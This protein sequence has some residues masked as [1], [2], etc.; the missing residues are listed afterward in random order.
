M[1]QDFAWTPLASLRLW[2]LNPRDNAEAIP[3]VAASIA[4]FGFVSPVVVWTSRSRIVAGHTRVLALARLLKKAPAFVPPGAPQGTPPG[5]APVRFHEFSSEEEATAYAIADNRLNELA[6]W[7]PEK[8]A[9]L[10]DALPPALVAVSGFDPATLDVLSALPG[11]IN[12][13]ELPDP[14]ALAESGAPSPKKGEVSGRVG[15]LRFEVTSVEATRFGAALDIWQAQHGTTAGF[16]S[17]LL[18]S[19]PS[20]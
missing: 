12:L 6:A 3:A 18:L 15:E 5:C 13:A 7:N 16:L 2:A 14:E 9:S 8:L 4:R 19:N 20:R 11:G 10:I 17:S 1:A